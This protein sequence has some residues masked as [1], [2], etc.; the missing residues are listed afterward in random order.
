MPRFIP[1]RAGNNIPAIKDTAK[2]RLV[3]TFFVDREAPAA[4]DA[5]IKV[6]CDALNTVA[7]TA[8]GTKKDGGS[9]HGNHH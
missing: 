6:C 1:A 8:P 3:A 7:P 9:C 4:T 5:M 2:Q